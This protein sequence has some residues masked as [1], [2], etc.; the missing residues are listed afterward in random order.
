[1]LLDGGIATIWK[2]VDV[3]EPGGMPKVRYTE[4]YFQS[5]YGEKTVGINRYWTA[6]AHDSR[7]DILIEIQRNAGISTNDRCQLTPFFDSAEAAYYKIVQ[8]QHVL[9]EDNLPMTDLTLE[10]I[11]DIDEP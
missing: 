5:Y 3:S 10:R 1:M 7:A 4:K 2:P 8:C 11:D 6:Q 9:D